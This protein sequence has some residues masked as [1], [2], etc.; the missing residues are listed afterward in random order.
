ML[1]KY[2]HFTVPHQAELQIEI[3]T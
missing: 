2:P 1:L 3:F